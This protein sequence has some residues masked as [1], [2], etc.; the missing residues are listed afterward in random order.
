MRRIAIVC[1][2]LALSACS[3]AKNAGRYAEQRLNP[4]AATRVALLSVDRL[5][6]FL[7]VEFRNRGNVLTFYAPADDEACIQLLRPEASVTYRK[8]GNFGRFE[9]GD[10]RCDPVGVGSLAAWRDRRPRDRRSGSIIPRASV[11]FREIGREDDVALVRGRFPLASRV[12][13]PSGFD[14]IAFLP[15]D[16]PA[17]ER[18]LA[19]GVGSMEFVPTGR[20]AIRIVGEGAPCPV[21][22]F[23]MPPGAAAPASE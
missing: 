11:Q 23:A 4:F 12:G 2:L 3:G 17:C 21:L 13:V 1:A 7:V 16:V 10:L 19:R 20:Q 18:P 9:D 6:P 22:G 5:G 8:H 14:L 15:L